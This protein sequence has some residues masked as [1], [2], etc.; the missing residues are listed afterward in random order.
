MD[1][2]NTLKT[3]ATQF[4]GGHAENLTNLSETAS[5][6]GQAVQGLGGVQGLIEKMNTSGLGAIASS[7]IAQGANEAISG[8]QIQ[9]LLGSDMVTQ[10][11]AKVGLSAEDSSQLV[12]KVLP[13]L[14][15]SMSPNGQLSQN[16]NIGEFVSKFDFAKLL[17]K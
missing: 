3:V 9:K 2:L 11:A 15:D 8:D 4:M 5:L 14:I 17:G 16:L 6:V 7:W 1:I 10:L 13:K 12:A